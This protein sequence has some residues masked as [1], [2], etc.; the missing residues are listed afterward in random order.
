MDENLAAHQLT[1]AQDYYKFQPDLSL[2]VICSPNSNVI[3]ARRNKYV[4]CG[5]LERVTVWCLRTGDQVACWEDSEVHTEVVLISACPTDEDLFA[6]AYAD[7]SIRLWNIERRAGERERGLTM[8]ERPAPKLVFHGHRAAVTALTFDIT[9]TRLASGSRDSEIIIWDLVSETGLVRLRGHSNAITGLLFVANDCLLSVS[10]DT[11]AKVWD[12]GSEHCVETVIVHHAEITDM[13]VIPGSR[14]EESGQ[15]KE[16]TEMKEE[17]RK[18]KGK[19]GAESRRKGRARGTEGESVNEEM[20]MSMEMEKSNGT[21]EDE[22]KEEELVVPRLM[23]ITVGADNKMRIFAVHSG[24][25]AAKVCNDADGSQSDTNIMELLETI[26]RSSGERAVAMTT[27]VAGRYCAVIGVDKSLELWKVRTREEWNKQ[28]G[29]KTQSWLKPI[30]FTRSLPAKPRSI[31]FTPAWKAVATEGVKLLLQLTDNRL[32]EVILPLDATR[33]I[34]WTGGECLEVLGHRSEPKVVALSQDGTLFATGAKEQVK[35]WNARSGRLLRSIALPDGGGE[36]TSLV[37]LNEDKNLLV[38]NATGSLHFVELSSGDIIDSVEAHGGPVRALCMRPDQKG[39]MS[40]GADKC[41]KFW[42]YKV[43]KHRLKHL[44]TLQLGDEIT[45]LCYSPDLR[46]IAAATLD[47]TVKVFFEDTLKFYLSLYGHKLPVTALDISADGKVLIS[48]SADKNVKVWS[49]EF[50]ECRKSIF[51]HS[52]AITAIA[53]IPGTMLFLTASKDRTIKYWDGGRFLE[54][55]QLTGHQG[56]IWAMEVSKDGETIVSVSRDRSI[57]VWRRSEEML[58]PEEERERALEEQFERSM[59]EENVYE[60]PEEEESS[61]PTIKTVATMKAGERIVECIEA[62]DDERRNWDEYEA[63]KSQGISMEEPTPGPFF[64]ALSRGRSQTPAD[65][66][67]AAFERI[68][69]PDVE[70]ALL[71]LPTSMLSSLLWYIRQWLEGRRNVVM[72]ARVLDMTLRLFHTAIMAQPGLRVLLESIRDLERLTLRQLKDIV[73]YNNV[74]ID[75][76]TV[77]RLL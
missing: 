40:G 33:E 25:L 41:I 66:V 37:F 61:R 36:C 24:R 65:F 31:Q 46:Y 45:Y 3:Y 56:E 71:C 57:R 63:A 9:G 47:M 53:F 20:G 12:L 70:E 28:K 29:K 69:L 30:R 51:A 64:L 6:V 68:P 52:E 34:S 7:G 17:G 58:F 39:L 55:Q 60:R 15:A 54:L 48:A 8:V 43:A 27:T 59:V 42:E 76:S 49:L 72:S 44:K 16:G 18:K 11:L 75:F 32:T 10:R 67:L 23:V 2:G 1:Q 13:C 19:D 5:T 74:I 21:V 73:G 62:A 4:V 14:G 77:D 22:D 26:T 35:V 38:G 50:G